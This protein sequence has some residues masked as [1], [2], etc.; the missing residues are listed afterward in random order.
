VAVYAALYDLVFAPVEALGLR[1]QRGRLVSGASGRVLEVGG[2]TGL[3]LAHY[4]DVDEVVVCEPDAAMR[5]GLSRRAAQARVPVTISPHGVPGLPFADDS[6][7]TVVCALVLCTVADPAG[8]LLDLR[9]VLR[10]DGQLLFLEHVLAHTAFGRV[11]RFAA[12]AWE[13]MFGG[14]RLDRDTVGAMRAAGFIL[15]DCER[16]HPF[17]RLSAQT[18]VCGRAVSRA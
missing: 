10:P 9:R 16:P 8:A 17:G 15:T 6:F 4:R 7:D 3:T 11:Q 2:G 12:P 13:R 5:P 18:V 14:C 1:A